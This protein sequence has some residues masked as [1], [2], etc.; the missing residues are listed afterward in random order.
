MS[1]SDVLSLA[2]PE[3]R[4]FRPYSS[5]RMEADEASVMLNANEAW[6]NGSSDG[7]VLLNRYPEPQPGGLRARLAELYEVAGDNVLMTRGSDEGMD[8]LLRAFCRAGK[9]A[10]LI[11]PPTFGMY[12]ISAGVQGAGVVEAPLDAGFGVDVDAILDAVSPAMKLVFL[13]SPN[14]PTGTLTPLAKIERLA[15]AL[16]GRA[17]L[18]VD[19]AYIEFADAPSAAALLPRHANL[20]VLRTLSKAWALAAARVGVVLAHREVAALLERIL[21]PYP[22]PAPSVEL[23]LQALSRPEAMRERIGR[24]RGERER[25]AGLLGA[26]TGVR[27]VLPSAANFLAVRFDDAHAIQAR[28]AAAGI[29]VRDLSGQPRLAD[30]L[31]ITIARSEDND[32]VLDALCES[33]YGGVAG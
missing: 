12:A 2:R 17:L 6:G 4:A 29:V 10:I 28:L 19:E 16:A 33:A 1:V 7:G 15:T 14:N 27:E 32:A 21:A 26:L 13:C 23:V 18:V 11:T 24:V 30:A 20:V 22:L 3:I 25:M 31:R 5:A 9:D 8:L